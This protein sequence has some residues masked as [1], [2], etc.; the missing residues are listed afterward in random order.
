[1]VFFAIALQRG[2]VTTVTAMTFVLEMVI[3]SAVGLFLFGDSVAAGT[4][5]IA[6]VG[7]VLAIAGTLALMRF[8]E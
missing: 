7:F 1:M 3:P 4:A 6:G 8:A 5:P 2:S